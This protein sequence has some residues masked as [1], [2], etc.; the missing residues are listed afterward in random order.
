MAVFSC[1]AIRRRDTGFSIKMFQDDGHTEHCFT[2]SNEVIELVARMLGD[3][4]VVT[5]SKYLEWSDK[6][7]QIKE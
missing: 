5:R 6:P 4:M 2:Q 3:E 7:I 1:I